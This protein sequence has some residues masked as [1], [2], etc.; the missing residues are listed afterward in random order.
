MV[1]VVSVQGPAVVAWREGWQQ[2]RAA[3]ARRGGMMAG[4][5]LDWLLL[6]SDTRA[7]AGLDRSR[8]TSRPAFEAR[9]PAIHRGT[10]H[11]T[12]ATPFAGILH[13]SRLTRFTVS[14]LEV[15][16]WGKWLRAAALL[17]LCPFQPRGSNDDASR[18]HGCC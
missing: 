18:G 10:L 2:H 6:E 5:H 16:M 9:P 15:E 3:A 1:V 11:G 17:H 13:V 12:P 14:C 7:A 4:P 8:S